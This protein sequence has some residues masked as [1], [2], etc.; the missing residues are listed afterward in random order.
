MGEANAAAQRNTCGHVLAPLFAP[1]PV[2]SAPATDSGRSYEFLKAIDEG[3]YGNVYACVQNPL[4]RIVAVKQ[5]KHAQDATVREML[6]C[7]VTCILGC[8][9]CLV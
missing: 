9:H 1:S 4:G 5:C 7:K 6:S 3:A 2:I 8:L